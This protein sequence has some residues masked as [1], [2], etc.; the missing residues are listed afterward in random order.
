VRIAVFGTG[1]VGGHFGGRL[2]LAGEQVAFVARGEHLAAIRR[3]GLVLDGPDGAERIVPVTVS[4]SPGEL[5]AAD[6][7]L[8]AVKTWQL[9][10][11]LAGIGPLLGPATFVVPLLNGV[12][13]ADRVAAALGAERVVPGLC[14]TVSWVEAPGQIRT[15]SRRNFVRFGE[16]DGRRTARCEALLAAFERAGIEAELR[17]DV[18]AALWEKLLFVVPVGGVGAATR[19]PI[20]VVRSL[21]AT[22][23][24]LERAMREIA[25]VAAARGVR[26]RDD[27]VERSLGFVDSLAPEATS[28]LQRDLEAGRRS[29]LDAWLGVVVRLGAELGVP[30]PVQHVHKGTQLPAEH[31]ARGE[32]PVAPV[33]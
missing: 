13:A 31:A 20:G 30:T 8:L 11:A 14:G 18:E 16:R 33:P 28:S 7:V 3:G 21:A 1:G 6:A 9:D 17:D 10:A 12:E 22:R 27:L 2:A 25:A 15:L 24:L 26:L 23:E 4:D 5:G 19:R 29:E 32:L